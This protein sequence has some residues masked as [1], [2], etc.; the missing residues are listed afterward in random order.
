M[1]ALTS[2]K[3]IN[4]YTFSD[5]CAAHY[6]YALQLLHAGKDMDGEFVSTL[7]KAGLYSNG[8]LRVFNYKKQKVKKPFIQGDDKNYVQSDFLRGLTSGNSNIHKIIGLYLLLLDTNLP[9][10]AIANST[11]QRHLRDAKELLPWMENDDTKA[12]LKKSM[13]DT[14]NHSKNNNYVMTLGTIYKNLTK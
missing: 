14:F 8:K 9:T 1:K 11:I 2:K 4:E 10:I 7:K 13:I 12:I 3:N 6:I 5:E